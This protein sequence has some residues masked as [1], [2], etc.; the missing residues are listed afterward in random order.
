MLFNSDNDGF[1]NLFEDVSTLV[2]GKSL[3]TTYK[4]LKITDSVLSSYVGIYKFP[5][6][7]TQ[8]IKVYKRDNRLFAELSN[9]SGNNMTMLAQS[10]TL[11]YLPDVRRIPTTIEFIIENGKVKGM[12][13][14][15]EKRHEGRKSE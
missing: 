11:F 13:W 2:I 4:D 12:Y 9:G 1:F 6:D 7:T 15:Q 8:F 3:Q 14:T 5:E 10:E